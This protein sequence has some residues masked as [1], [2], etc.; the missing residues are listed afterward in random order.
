MGDRNIPGQEAGPAPSDSYPWRMIVRYPDGAAG[1][2][3]LLLRLS[4]ALIAFATL[5]RWWPAHVDW[6]PALLPSAALAMALLAGFGTRISAF[7]LLLALIA[8]LVTTRGALALLLIASGGTAGAVALLG[9]GAYS[10]DARR[11]GRRIIRLERR[12]PDRGGG[13]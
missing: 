12:L 4:C 2:A 5:G 8:D 6:W 7:V 13:D 11:F 1:I 3:L 9:P 10:I